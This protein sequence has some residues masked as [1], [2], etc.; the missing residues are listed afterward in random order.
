M[1][2]QQ[3]PFVPQLVTFFSFPVPPPKFYLSVGYSQFSSAAPS[4]ESSFSR[5][6]VNPVCSNPPRTIFMYNLF[7]KHVRM[8]NRQTNI[9][10]G[11]FFRG[12]ITFLEFLQIWIYASIRTCNTD[13]PIFICIDD[14]VKC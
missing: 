11:R 3:H 2:L 8:P 12:N 6:T 14:G 7:F 13:L 9:T 4:D 5:V 10:R 1:D